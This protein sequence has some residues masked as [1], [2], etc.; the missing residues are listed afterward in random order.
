[1]I[2]ASSANGATIVQSFVS[3]KDTYVR[4]GAFANSNYGTQTTAQVKL[5]TGTTNPSNT[6]ESYL[7]F[8]LTGLAAGAIVDAALTLQFVDS[9]IGATN[10]TSLWNFA[11]YGLTDDSWGETTITWNNAPGVAGAPLATFSLQ[12]KGLGQT[13]IGSVSLLSYLL[14][15]DSLVSLAL[16]RTTSGAAPE[17]YVHAFATRENS[18]I[19]FRPTL[20]LTIRTAE[21]IPAPATA[22]LLA[23]GL[24]GLG[25]AR[26][27]TLANA[28]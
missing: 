7:G 6:R 8:D 26:R 22:A 17:G 27:R 24:V 2:K 18:N 1:M 4:S 19:A 20:A 10:P 3:A 13:T 11:L 21:T 28:G 5:E 9:G 14:S 23:L 15:Q 25:A 12:G 16:V